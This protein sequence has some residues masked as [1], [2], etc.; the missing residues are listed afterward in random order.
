MSY[1]IPAFLTYVRSEYLYTLKEG[2]GYFTPAT[3]FAVSLVAGESIKFHLMADDSVMFKNIPIC[4]L[5]NSK[6]APKISEQESCPFV[7]NDSNIQIISYDHLSNIQNCATWNDNGTLSNKGTYLFSI[8]SQNS[9][10]HIIEIENGN[11][12]CWDNPWVSWGE[13]VPEK[14]HE[15]IK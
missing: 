13:E 6:E 2:F 11:Y 4:A 9:L 8:E 1:D 7:C 5:A 10:F 3:V 12:V 15:Y 14:M